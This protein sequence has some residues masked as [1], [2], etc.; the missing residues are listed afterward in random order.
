VAE[1]STFAQPS[2]APNDQA[3]LN[4]I[5][6]IESG[7]N[8]GRARPISSYQTNIVE[9]YLN[10]LRSPALVVSNLKPDPVTGIVK[11]EG[12][13]LESYSTLQIIT[14]NPFITVT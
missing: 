11:I 6:Q 9:S 1:G 4:H 8:L 3:L 5:R 2:S 14:T 12:L 13:N 10:F 7:T